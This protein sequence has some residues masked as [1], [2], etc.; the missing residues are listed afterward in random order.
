M[1]KV[2]AFSPSL[3]ATSVILLV[4][5][6]IVIPTVHAQT[7]TIT[8]LQYPRQA[9]SPVTITFT[10][11]Y[12]DIG[13]A[14][15]AFGI[16][17]QDTG[18]W[19]KGSGTSTPD[20]CQSTAGTQYANSAICWTKPPP[21]SS[22][23]EDASF[24][25]AFDSTQEYS[26][27][28]EVWMFGTSGNTV[29]GSQ[30]YWDFKI[31]VTGQS[32]PS[33]TAITNLQYPT[34]AVLQN[35]VAQATVT[36]TLDYTGLPSGDFLALGILYQPHGSGNYVTGSG[37]STPDSC[38][39]TAGTKYANSA[40]C[41]A[42]PSSS[43]GTESVSF[44]L[45]FN[46]TQQ[47]ALYLVAVMGDKSGNVVSSATS[48]SDF[49]ISVTTQTAS[50]TT[51]TTATTPLTSTTSEATEAPGI[52]GIPSNLLIVAVV[53]AVIVIVGVVFLMRRRAAGPK[54]QEITAPAEPS[55]GPPPRMEVPREIEA[56][57]TP[58]PSPG[59]GSKYCVHCGATIPAVVMFCTK[60][61]KK[62]E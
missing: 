56:P 41:V 7:T 13:G 10:A 47:N 25:L 21:T 43:S 18:N 46:S 40:L 6:M 2:A 37:T 24:T 15:L 22:G 49:T 20:S 14:G 34:Q 36:F 48:F 23:T 62:Q 45:T 61:G 9:L 42:T 26:L 27:R 16:R 52:G 54:M 5:I 60:C 31:S 29:V 53:V 12:L 17:D 57:P 28:A 1:K 58:R 30:S 11:G 51:A 19:V 3:Q 32:A 44:N 33:T 35:G 55:R 39:S 8:K 38:T 59:Q 4:L 50:P